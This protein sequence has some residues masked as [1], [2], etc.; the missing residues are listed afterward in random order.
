MRHASILIVAGLA[1]CQAPSAV[2]VG[3]LESAVQVC[4]GPKTL[5][6]IDV[7]T[8]QGTIDWTKVKA[9]GRAWAIARVG[10]GLGNDNQFAANWAGMKTVGM[11]RGVYQFFRPGSDPIA[12]ADLLLGK[13]GT[14]GDGDLAPALDIEVTDGQSNATITANMTKWLQHVEAKTG[15]VPLIYT[16][17][18]FWSSLGNPNFGHYTLWVA[19]WQVSCPSVP[20][21][22]TAWPF[23]QYADNGTVPGISGAVDLDRFDGDIGMLMGYAG[24]GHSNS[25]GGVDGGGGAVD[26]SNGGGGAGG[27]GGG[28]AGGGGT[29]GGGAGGGS[30]TGG[31]G[32]K[33]DTPA[34]HSGCS[35][36]GA[37]SDGAAPWVMLLVAMA[38]LRASRRRA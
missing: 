4:Q 32:G 23:W 24:G 16:S 3:E 14:L 13:I 20:S 12:Q 6:G 8:Y 5:E 17:P 31:N 10:D 35:L 18:G 34:M 19:N 9:S 25:D 27:G 33:G 38:L 37:R 36:A 11:V 22:W 21:G 30:G 2:A 1:A 7:S 28:A 26:M 29:G 15:R